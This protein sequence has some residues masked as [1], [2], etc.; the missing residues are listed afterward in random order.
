M[1]QLTNRPRNQREREI[2]L[3]FQCIDETN[4]NKD[5][6]LCSPILLHTQKKKQ[7]NMF[8]PLGFEKTKSLRKNIK[9]FLF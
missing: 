3:L 6:A 2:T 8:Q 5:K 1:S 4:L 7:F 9:T